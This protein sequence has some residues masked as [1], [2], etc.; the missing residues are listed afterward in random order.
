MHHPPQLPAHSIWVLMAFA[1][2]L[3]AQQVYEECRSRLERMVLATPTKRS[4]PQSLASKLNPG[5]VSAVEEKLVSHLRQFGSLQELPAAAQPVLDHPSPPAV[6]E[7]QSTTTGSSAG[8]YNL[9]YSSVQES[10]LEAV[11]D[12][13][14][15]G[16][17]QAMMQSQFQDQHVR[18]V[19]AGAGAG[20]VYS[21]SSGSRSVQTDVGYE[22]DTVDTVGD[23]ELGNWPSRSQYR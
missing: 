5:D 3:G 8:S 20:S 18:P 2:V 14:H 9:L 22:S 17:P 13:S 12:I 10:Y 23:D 1:E 7:Q 21:R 16:H 15:T 19:G 11:N 6:R 4:L